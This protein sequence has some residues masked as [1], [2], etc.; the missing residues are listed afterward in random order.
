MTS[1]FSATQNL[2]SPIGFSAGRHCT[3]CDKYKLGRFYNLSE[4]DSKCQNCY[5]K[6]R[7]QTVQHCTACNK[8]KNGQFIRASETDLECFLCYK[9]NRE[10]VVQHCTACNKDKN[11]QFYGE[12]EIDL[13]CKVCYNKNHYQER[14]ALGLLIEKRE[15]KFESIKDTTQ[16]PNS[17]TEKR[18]Y[19]QNSD[20]SSKKSRTD[21]EDTTSSRETPSSKPLSPFKESTFLDADFLKTLEELNLLFSPSRDLPTSLTEKRPDSQN[22][23]NSSKKVESTTNSQGTAS[24][25]PLSPFKESTFLDADFLKN[26]EDLDDWK[27]DL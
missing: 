15:K 24:S 27:L 12:S 26:L 2:N 7:A 21:D 19:S 1:A 4:T 23:D 5:Q 13:K 8:D 18:P 25:R 22:S 14:K 3:V 20:N 6:K 17:L 11:G 16:L 9:K 10:Q